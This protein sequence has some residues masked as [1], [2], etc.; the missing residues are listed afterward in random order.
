MKYPII[1]LLII[2]VPIVMADRGEIEIYLPEEVLDLSV[3]LSNRTGV[4]VGADCQV[5]IRN[6]TYKVIETI[7]MNEI[8][9]GW[10]NATYNT[11][12]LGKYFCRQN[13]TQG[14]FFASETCDFIIEG[15]KQMP[16][17]VILTVIFVIG[18]Y[19][20]I[21]IRL[22]TERSFTEHGMVKLLFFLTAFWIVLLPLDMA[23]QFNTFNGGPV[24]VT[25]HLNTLYTIMVFLNYFITIYF[26]LWFIIQMIRKVGNTKNKIRFGNE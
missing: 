4:V 26:M 13:C 15:D 5:E 20:F 21:L 1:L 10:Y 24:V 19:F 7:A 6:D 9:G 23:V 17:S 11:S 14:S 12:V 22:F 18:V 3:H 2:F 8:D 25:D 16:I